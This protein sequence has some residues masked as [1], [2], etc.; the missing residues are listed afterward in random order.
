MKIC[1]KPDTLQI[2]DD[3]KLKSFTFY[4]NVGNL[5]RRGPQR[6]KSI[7]TRVWH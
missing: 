1:D 5:H 4:H 7:D 2:H 6:Q 3:T